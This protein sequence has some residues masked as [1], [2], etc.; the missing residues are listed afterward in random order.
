MSSSSGHIS[1]HESE[2]SLMFS[3]P[4]QQSLRRFS[5]FQVGNQNVDSRAHAVAM[6][7]LVMFV[8]PR[9]AFGDAAAGPSRRTL[10]D[11]STGEVPT[12]SRSADVRWLLTTGALTASLACDFAG[13]CGRSSLSGRD[14]RASW[15]CR[16]IG[17]VGC[18]ERAARVRASR[19]VVGKSLR[20]I[21][22][23]LSKLT[24]QSVGTPSSVAV[25]SGSG[26]ARGRCT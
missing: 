18:P 5:I 13:S 11:G 8:R 21:V 3:R 25:S 10:W 1:R 23:M 20:E 19:S 14:D 9:T 17:G 26:R 24:T 2:C 12:R 16:N 15:S 6:S 22:W 7:C 4:C